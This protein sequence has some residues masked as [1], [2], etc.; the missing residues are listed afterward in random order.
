MAWI[1]RNLYFLLCTLV[2]AGLMGWGGFYLYS[3]WSNEQDITKKIADAYHVLKQ[4]YDQNPNPG[5]G[6]VDNVKAARDQNAELVEYIKNARA[7]FQ[8]PA[9]IPDEPKVVNADFAAELGNTVAELAHE[10]A[11][12][13]VQL[14]HEYNFTFEAQ[15]HLML[16]D[17]ASLNKLAARLGE[18]KVI[19][20]ILFNAKVNA[21]DG[22]RREVVSATDDK[23][24]PDYLSKST[25]V[26]PL[27]EVTP[28]EVTFR[29]FSAELAAVLG[30]LANSQY[31]FVVR[32]INVTPASAAVA[33]VDASGNPVQPQQ[34]N[35]PAASQPVVAGHGATRFLGEQQLR[36]TLQIMVVKLKPAK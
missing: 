16:F 11:E 15:R 20:E 3:A 32:S 36:V 28:Y 5:S 18:I 34:P 33:T 35:T 9:P 8:S 24:T 25:V 23:N 21:V 29:C 10:A 7:Y 12:D 1:K 22:L 14:P 17:P 4:L 26:T 2:A 13:N 6:D 27:G 30:G 31:C 19:S